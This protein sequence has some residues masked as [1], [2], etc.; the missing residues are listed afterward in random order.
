M[1]SFDIQ[2]HAARICPQSSLQIFRTFISGCAV[3]PGAGSFE[4]LRSVIVSEWR[5]PKGKL[6]GTV[7]RKVYCCFVRHSDP[8][9]VF[10]EFEQHGTVSPH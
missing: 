10:A 2:N 4:V 9:V 6:S 3:F 1:L 8:D 7:E 5:V